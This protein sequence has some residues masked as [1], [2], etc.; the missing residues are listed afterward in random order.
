MLSQSATLA[1]LSNYL[2]ALPG[3]AAGEGSGV[4]TAA[5]QVT[6]VAQECP[7]AMGG[8]KK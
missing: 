8:A 6:A 4:V 2:P 3:G 7:R 5:A 1:S